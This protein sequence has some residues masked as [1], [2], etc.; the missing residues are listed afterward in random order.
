MYWIEDKYS[1]SW[2][3]YGRRQEKE[4]IMKESCKILVFSDTHGD[5]LVQNQVIRA[6][7]PFD[8][9]IH[10]GDSEVSLKA[11]LDCQDQYKLI[12]VAGNCDGING[13]KNVEV[14]RVAFYNILVLHGH[15]YFI[16][17]GLN[18]ALELAKKE[19]ADVVC[20]GHTHTPEIEEDREN[21]I[22][23]INPGSLTKNRPYSR[24]GTY[25][26]LTISWDELPKAEIKEW[27]D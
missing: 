23:F 5:L 6:E 27:E 4:N 18:F 16:K 1:T 19:C 7:L 25:A 22:L 3:I 12:S 9:L 11:I 17:S 8:Y 15:N 14:E 26:V 20:F 2:F 24:K 13:M 21:G 10:C